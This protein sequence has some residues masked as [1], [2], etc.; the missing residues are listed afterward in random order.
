MW[1]LFWKFQTGSENV[2]KLG[3][4]LKK[5]TNF[6]KGMQYSFDLQ[7]ELSHNS[8]SVFFKSRFDC[9]LLVAHSL[10]YLCFFHLTRDLSVVIL[11][12]S[13]LE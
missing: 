4:L 11:T 1:F 5:S 12:V 9:R 6:H 10:W 13:N 3:R 2:S 8:C 7:L